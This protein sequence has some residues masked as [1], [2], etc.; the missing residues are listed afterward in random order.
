MSVSGAPKSTRQVGRTHDPRRLR[1]PRPTFD[2][3]EGSPRRGRGAIEREV[4]REQH[5]AAGGA[6]EA[7]AR[8]STRASVMPREQ[9]A[10]GRRARAGAVRASAPRVSTPTSAAADDRRR[11]SR[12]RRRR[13]R[14]HGITVA[15]SAVKARTPLCDDT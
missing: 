5:D 15:A 9:V 2:V 4:R 8:Q 7:S 14:R 1:R 3:A 11:T 12:V 6:A 13:R 10:A